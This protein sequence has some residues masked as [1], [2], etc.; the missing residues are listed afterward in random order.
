MQNEKLLQKQKEQ[1]VKE[2][3]LKNKYPD[4]DDQF[5]NKDE[6][7]YPFESDYV[8][9]KVLNNNTKLL[10]EKKANISDLA[11][12]SRETEKLIIENTVK[13]INQKV[14]NIGNDLD[15]KLKDVARESSKLK[16]ENT[17]LDILSKVGS[18]ITE[19]SSIKS[20]LN[21]INSTVNTI[22]SKVDSIYNKL[23]SGGTTN[24]TIRWRSIE[25][26]IS[27]GSGSQFIGNKSGS[28]NVIFVN[29][30]LGYSSRNGGVK[31]I[32]ITVSIESDTFYAEFPKSLDDYDSV[33]SGVVALSYATKE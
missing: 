33:S 1:T 2:V 9:V 22:R 27:S 11:D 26:S 6:L 23:M 18:L 14:G 24:E 21:T 30:T 8:N 13:S 32:P 16:I 17:L 12:V 10:D 25:K 20:L 28:G 4:A 7:E 19:T 5:T 3:E 31:Q 29:A 15:S